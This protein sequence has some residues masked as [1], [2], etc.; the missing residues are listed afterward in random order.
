[1]WLKRCII[2]CWTQVINRLWDRQ[3]DTKRGISFRIC[4]RPEAIASS[5]NIELY[6]K[7]S[8]S[9]QKWFLALLTR[10]LYWKLVSTKINKTIILILPYIVGLHMHRFISFRSMWKGGSV[11]R[12]AT[13]THREQHAFCRLLNSMSVLIVQIANFPSPISYN[14]LRS[15]VIQLKSIINTFLSRLRNYHNATLIFLSSFT[16][17]ML[18]CLPSSMLV[19]T[20]CTDRL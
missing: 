2:W 10:W 13:A 14:Q 8:F 5:K 9:N 4:L 6:C 15:V 12:M 19:L 16:A 11:A 18:P 20:T 3:N 1:M 7:H 17:W